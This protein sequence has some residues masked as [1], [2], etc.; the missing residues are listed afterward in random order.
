MKRLCA[1]SVVVITVLLLMILPA[2]ALQ[3]SQ[4]EF[5]LH[6]PAGSSGTYSFQVINNESDPQE[7]IV[8]LSDWTRTVEGDND[9][10]PL[11]GARWLFPRTFSTDEEMEILYR[12]TLPSTD[13]TV[14]GTYT[15]GSPSA[16]GQITGESLLSSASV[17]QTPPPAA[18]EVVR[19]TREIVS[20]SPAGDTVT[21]RLH[22]RVL[23]DIAGLRL[24]EVFSS[25]AQIESI[26][27]A[28]GEFSAVARSNGDWL[29]VTPQRFKIDAGQVQEVTFRIQV[30]YGAAGTYWGMIFVEGSPR[31]QER[32]GATVLAIERFGVK[33]YE[34]VP[35]TE[36]LSGRVLQVRKTADDPLTFTVSFENTGNVQ[37][38]PTGKIDIINQN[39]DTVRTLEIEEFPILPQR[40]R[41]LT[42]A[43]T[44]DRSL[45]SGIYRALVTVDYGGDNLTG[46][47]R[48][49]RLR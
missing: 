21:V 31:P 18:D 17:G 22:V 40:V 20:L 3:I 43:D 46:G 37:L 42:V 11:N 19:V 49:F 32:E 47:T 7:I 9:F 34:T 25:H 10:L 15:C 36:V 13:L 27:A 41:T 33:I 24:D 16:Q 35:G 48:D 39:G 38:R 23:Q 4:I 6:I 45:P 26:D 30:P 2:C 28:G 29:T 8:Y 14:S 1:V 5:D 44:L 12:V